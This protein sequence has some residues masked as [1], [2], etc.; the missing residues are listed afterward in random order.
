MSSIETKRRKASTQLT[1]DDVESFLDSSSCDNLEEQK[2]IDEPKEIPLNR[3][4]LR[5]IRRGPQQPVPESIVRESVKDV[6]AI[7]TPGSTS[8]SPSSQKESLPNQSESLPNQTESPESGEY[9]KTTEPDQT[10]L[11]KMAHEPKKDSISS[12]DGHGQEEH[13]LPEKPSVPPGESNG[14]HAPGTANVLGEGKSAF[15][16]LF[17]NPSSGISA[18]PFQ[19]QAAKGESGFLQ[20]V[21]QS[22]NANQEKDDASSEEPE[23]PAPQVDN[24]EETEVAL[25]EESRVALK[26]FLKRDASAAPSWGGAALGRLRLLAPKEGTGTRPRVILR[27]IGTNAVMLN[28]CLHLSG[29]WDKLD[30]A[31]RS[32]V[33]FT[34]ID[35]EKKRRYWR[36]FVGPALCSVPLARKAK[37]VLEPSCISI[38]PVRYIVRTSVPSFPMNCTNHS[39]LNNSLDS[40]MVVS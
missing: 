6:Q 9:N 17:G 40:F 30:T 8:T 4:K 18:D 31:T 22:S 29:K 10:F 24:G 13:K 12:P 25:F 15:A 11:D 19:I 1:K 16:N 38:T 26:K 3:P 14:V 36:G 20:S 37:R 7:N 27:S 2:D 33:T 32:G 39:L 34:A 21:A 35:Q 28:S 23:E 5:I